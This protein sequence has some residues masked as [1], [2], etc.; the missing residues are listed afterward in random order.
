MKIA[1]SANQTMGGG[2][3]CANL[4]ILPNFDLLWS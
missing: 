4:A 2:V 1:Q 3:R